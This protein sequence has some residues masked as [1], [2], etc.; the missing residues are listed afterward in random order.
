MIK[1]SFVK[2]IKNDYALFGSAIVV[3]LLIPFVVYNIVKGEFNAV[4]V[5]GSI[6]LCFIFLFLWRLLVIK[7]YFNDSIELEGTITKIWFYKDRGRV[8]FYYKI[9]TREFGKGHAIMKTKAT[10]ALNKGQKVK[11]LIKNRNH[12]KAIIADLYS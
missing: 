2:S 6:D 5:F 4:Y 10:L 7:S 8:E 11:L 12:Q 1:F 9:E 3:I